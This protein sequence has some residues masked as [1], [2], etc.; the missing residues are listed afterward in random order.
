[1]T[2]KVVVTPPLNASYKH[3]SA[4]EIIQILGII[5]LNY[6]EYEL[7]LYDNGKQTLRTSYK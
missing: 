1:M 4:P 2:K 5:N 6:S 7:D 3:Q